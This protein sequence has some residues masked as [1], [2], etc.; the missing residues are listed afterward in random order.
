MTIEPPQDALGRR[1]ESIMGNVGIDHIDGADSVGPVSATDS[2]NPEHA[3]SH[4][5]AAGS[6]TNLDADSTEA[7][8]GGS[9]GGGSAGYQVIR[10]LVEW[11]SVVAT[12]LAIALLI[13][14][15]VFQA[16]EIPS[17]SMQSTLM[18]DDRIVV[19]KL[20]YRVGEV[21]RGQLMV[22]SKIEGTVSDTDELI[23]RVIALPGETIEVRDDGRI[24]IWGPGET[25]ADATVLDEPY[26]DAVHE[27]FLAPQSVEAPGQ[28]IWHPNC[29]NLIDEGARCTLDDSSY[30][31]LGDNRSASTDSRS[32]GPVPDE[33]VVGRA[34]VRIW[35]LSAIGGL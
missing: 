24:W 3:A 35:P 2:L 27:L 14:A 7:T 28:N 11:I 15:F 10:T 6:P 33:N 21:Q 12:A 8:G 4:G 29:T 16:F 22:F 5:V 1:H 23:K 30:F 31:M 25:E 13:K 18:I 32:F 17:G 20:S 19:N 9:A 34:V 26:L